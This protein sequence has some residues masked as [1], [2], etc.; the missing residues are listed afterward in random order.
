[1][2]NPP[3]YPDSICAACGLD[4]S[5]GR[6]NALAP[7]EQGECGWCGREKA[8]TDPRYFGHPRYD[9]EKGAAQ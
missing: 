5:T 6:P 2:D 4:H 3:L 1:M 9:P 8:V 7:Y